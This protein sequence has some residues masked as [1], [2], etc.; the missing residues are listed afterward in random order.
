MSNRIFPE[1]IKR[2][3]KR[4]ILSH[5]FKNIWIHPSADVDIKSTFEGWNKIH[6]H[7]V[8]NGH[9]GY[10][11]YIGENSSIHGKIGRFTSIAPFC[12]ILPG[13]HPTTY[14]YATTSPVFYSNLGQ[15][16]IS[17]ASGQKFNEFKWADIK[18]KYAVVIGNDVWIQGR[19]MIMSGVTIGDGA[20]I[21]SG[22]IVT[23]DVP[24]YAIVGGIPA[25]IMK[26]RY[27]EEDIDFLLKYQWWNKGE[28]WWKENSEILL[29]IDKLKQ[30]A[31]AESNT[32]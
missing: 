10:C 6:R 29:D 31:D 5:K 26:Y 25:K 7:V 19:V 3:I 30:Y 9:I 8:F 20:I 15:C 24:P 12:T 23:K 1:S 2:F 28:N 11:S 18:N 27:K 17:Y 16:G 21:L 22:A 14:P 13:I 4:I 32:K